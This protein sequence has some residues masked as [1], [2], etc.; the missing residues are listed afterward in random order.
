MHFRAQF[1]RKGQVFVQSRPIGGVEVGLFHVGGQQGAVEAAG[2]ALSAFEH[3]AG[4]AARCQTDKDALL[5][6]PGGRNAVRVEVFLQVP[7]NDVG[8]EEEGKFA[9]FGK[10]SR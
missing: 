3:G 10:Y 4:V 9:E 5:G 7:V 8:G 2:V 6:T 1:T